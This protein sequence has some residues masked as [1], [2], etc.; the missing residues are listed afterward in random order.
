[1]R[2]REFSDAV[3]LLGLANQPPARCVELLDAVNERRESCMAA[4]DKVNQYLNQDAAAAEL[5]DSAR[6][7]HERSARVDPVAHNAGGLG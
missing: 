1:M 5:L 3:A 6:A 2:T 4:A 7:V